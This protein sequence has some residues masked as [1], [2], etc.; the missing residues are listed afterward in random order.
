MYIAHSTYEPRKLSRTGHT[1]W[2][3]TKLDPKDFLDGPYRPA[4]FNTAGQ[5]MNPSATTGDITIVSSTSFFTADMVDAVITVGTA[6]G[7]GYI[8]ALN[9][10]TSVD[11]TVVSTLSTSTA[12]TTW[13]LGAWNTEWGFPGAVS[14]YEQRLAFA[15]STEF[16]Q[17]VWLSVSEIY[18]DMTG[19]TDADDALLYT[20]ATEQVNVIRWL[21]AEKILAMGT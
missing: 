17:T 2:T 10:G 4:Q 15:G 20:I 7:Y 6:G 21:S 16:P 1:A 11:V 9:S 3:L 19:G 18:E 8:T 12:T 14:F 13:K 5:T